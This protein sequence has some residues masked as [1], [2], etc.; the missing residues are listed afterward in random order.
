MII[1]KKLHVT[2]GRSFYL[3]LMALLAC[4]VPTVLFHSVV[5]S[6]NFTVAKSVLMALGADMLIARLLFKL[7]LNQRTD[8]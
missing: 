7:V 5:S 6:S 8:I 1:L 3:W 4:E 2:L